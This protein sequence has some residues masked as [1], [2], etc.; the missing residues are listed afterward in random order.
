MRSFNYGRYVEIDVEVYYDKADRR[1][2]YK[3]RDYYS[4]G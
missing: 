3:G 2:G 4:E 1:R